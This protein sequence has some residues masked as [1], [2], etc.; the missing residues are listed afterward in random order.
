MVLLEFREYQRIKKNSD[1]YL[2]HIKTKSNESKNEQSIGVH[3]KVSESAAEKE[4]HGDNYSVSVPDKL[5]ENCIKEQSIFEGKSS[6]ANLSDD[7]LSLV[8]KKHRASAKNLLS[9]LTE[10]SDIEWDNFGEITL[11]NSPIK[12]SRLKHLIPLVFYGTRKGELQ[13][14]KEFFQYLEEQSDLKHYIGSVSSTDW[15]YIGP[16]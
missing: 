7:W 6:P 4:G 8:P 2:L 10:N 9:Q 5:P 16:P 12:G 14:E 3:S 11:K 1:T 15:F 13:G